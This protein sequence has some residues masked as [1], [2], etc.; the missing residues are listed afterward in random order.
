MPRIR[1]L[2][3]PCPQCGA[4]YP[5]RIERL[6]DGAPFECLACGAQVALGDF[7]P[8]LELINRYSE[9]VLKLEQHAVIDGESASPIHK[10]QVGPRIY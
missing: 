7:A 8:L 9:A 2:R 6:T 5:V 4:E 3:V 1:F 10:A